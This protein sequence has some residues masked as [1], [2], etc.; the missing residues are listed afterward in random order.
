MEAPV[1]SRGWSRLLI[2]H[3]T[4]VTALITVFLLLMA[5][6]SPEQGAN[7]GAGLVALPV[8]VMGL[9]WSLPFLMDP[10]QFDGLSRPAWLV[11]A[12]GPAVLNVALHGVVVTFVR[13]RRKRFSPLQ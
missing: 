3:A 9:P 10:Y 13:R 11:V 2:A 12:F 8:L 6:S 5:A 4:I 7:I 1:E